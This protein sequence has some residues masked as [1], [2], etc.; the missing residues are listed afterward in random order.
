[1]YEGVNILMEK[2]KLAYTKWEFRLYKMDSVKAFIYV[3]IKQMG[4]T[5]SL[6]PILNM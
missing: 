5:E 6:F 3:V 4:F 2:S 1:M